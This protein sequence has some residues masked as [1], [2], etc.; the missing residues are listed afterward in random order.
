[1]L[2]FS[3]AVPQ[4]GRTSSLSCPRQRSRVEVFY[5]LWATSQSPHWEGGGTEAR[6]QQEALQMHWLTQPEFFH[7][8]W[9]RARQR[10]LCYPLSDS[11]LHSH[12]AYLCW[13]AQKVAGPQLCAHLT[14]PSPPAPV[15]GLGNGRNQSSGH[16]CIGLQRRESS[17]YPLSTSLELRVNHSLSPLDAEG[18]SPWNLYIHAWR[19]TRET[20]SVTF[21]KLLNIQV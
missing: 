11:S 8:S 19:R 1:M 20:C 3:S 10:G 21:M 7:G 6:Y 4:A 12:L 15:G 5:R 13:L 16:V 2:C 17:L 14:C 9:G 18:S